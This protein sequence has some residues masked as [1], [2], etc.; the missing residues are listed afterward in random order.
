MQQTAKKGIQKIPYSEAKFDSSLLNLGPAR[1]GRPAR[2]TRYGVE[3]V[4]AASLHFARR[5][6][7][8]VFYDWA[9][10]SS[11][12]AAYKSGHTHFHSA[13]Y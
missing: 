8:I 10:A 11:L 3:C 7:I 1:A 4:W 9:S 6:F 13:V 5:I 2:S 12:G